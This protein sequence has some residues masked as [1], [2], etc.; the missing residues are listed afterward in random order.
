MDRT[1]ST[2]NEAQERVKISHFTKQGYN[3]RGIVH[4]GANDGYEIDF[5]LQM[6]IKHVMAFEPILPVYEKLMARYEGSPVVLYAIALGNIDSEACLNITPG[7]G[8]GSSFLTE[9]RGSETVMQP[10]RMRRLASMDYLDLSDYNCCVID[11]QG[12]ELDVLRGMDD[13]LQRFDFLSVECSER[14]IYKG[15]ASAEEVI[16]FLA[17]NGFVRDS[18]VPEHDDVM[19]IH[20]RVL[21]GPEPEKPVPAGTRLNIGSGQRRFD[22]AY[23]WVNVDCVSR[24]GQV[25]DLLCDVGRDPLPYADNSMDFVVLS[26]VYEH[27]GL[28]EGHGVVREAHRVLKPGGSLILTVPDAKA[29]AQRWMLG[30]IDD[31]IYNVN[32]YGAYQGEPGDR[33]KWSYTFNALAKDLA[34]IATWKVVQNFNS[35]HISGADIAADWWILGVAAVK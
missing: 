16:A 28:G 35:A 31:Y 25:P 1:L 9:I 27:F 19:F 12:M 24:P 33:H 26:Q 32:M 2:F 5:Y 10:A 4:V 23:G 21:H 11:V 17:K 14:P 20:K 15:E 29:L 30:Q 3:I 13:L 7:D 8:K 18:P 34:S 6:G 22:T